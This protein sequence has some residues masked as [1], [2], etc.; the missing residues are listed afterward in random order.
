MPSTTRPLEALVLKR[1]PLVMALAQIRFSTVLAMESFVPA[2]QERLRKSYPGFR[3]ANAQ[4]LLVRS[5]DGSIA[6]RRSTRWLFLDRDEREAVVLTPDFLV[7][8]TADYNTFEEFGERL[9]HVLQVVQSVAE[10]GFS[11]RV[12]LRFIDRIVPQRGEQLASYVQAGLAGL[13]SERLHEGSLEVGPTTSACEVRTETPM[14]GHLVIRSFEQPP[15]KVSLPQGL[16]EQDIRLDL[17]PCERNT[18]L[19]DIDHFVHERAEFDPDGLMKT[20][21]ELHAYADLAFRRSTTDFA[22]QA[23]EREVVPCP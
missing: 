10:I 14:G 5:D 1:S 19:L 9:E 11:E 15:G 7:L 22:M 2:I 21:W 8:Q 18:L 20:A 23:W 6:A 16:E 3:E 12:G 17:E 4:E 13:S